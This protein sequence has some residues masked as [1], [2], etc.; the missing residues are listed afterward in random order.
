MLAKPAYLASLRKFTSTSILGD[1]WSEI[2][3]YLETNI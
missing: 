3:G 2:D 1:T